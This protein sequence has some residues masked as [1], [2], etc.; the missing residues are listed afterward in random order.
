MQ[1]TTEAGAARPS[2]KRKIAAALFAAAGIGALAYSAWISR[3]RYLQQHPPPLPN[4]VAPIPENMMG[5][6]RLGLKFVQT[7]V[8][9]TTPD[10][11]KQIDDLWK[12]P[13]RSLTEAIEIQKK[14]D[15]I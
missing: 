10:Q 6:L 3:Q 4:V 5:P 2:R 12:T 15:Q 7:S 11:E 1:N 14:M 8:L 9:F 13:P